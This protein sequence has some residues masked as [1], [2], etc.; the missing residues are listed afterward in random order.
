M[1]EIVIG[2]DMADIPEGTYPATLTA[3]NTKSSAK[4]GGDFRVWTFKLDNGSEVEGTSSMF[5][6]PKSKPGRW[7]AALL[8]RKPKEG[9]SVNLI[10]QRCLVSVVESESGWPK[11]DAVIAAPNGLQ[12]VT[13]GENGPEH[14]AKVQMY[15]GMGDDPPALTE[16]P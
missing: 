9:E 2:G 15:D 5:T 14:T 7:I 13:V 16:L 11:V 6:G 4:F 10:G 3:L 12:P 1:T 8:G